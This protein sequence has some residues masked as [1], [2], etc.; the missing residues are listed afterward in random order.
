MRGTSSLLLSTL[1]TTSRHRAKPLLTPAAMTP[2]RVSR[3]PPVDDAD[4]TVRSRYWDNLNESTRPES[5]WPKPKRQ[6]SQT[7]SS[8]HDSTR[9]GPQSSP[10]AP[11]GPADRQHF[12]RTYE[13]AFDFKPR[14]AVNVKEEP[15]EESLTLRATTLTRHFAASKALRP[16]TPAITRKGASVAPKSTEP[17]Q[18]PG[19]NAKNSQERFAVVATLAYVRDSAVTEAVVAHVLRWARQYAASGNG[20]VYDTEF[21]QSIFADLDAISIEPGRRAVVTD[22]LTRP[23]QQ[24]LESLRSSSE[25]LRSCLASINTPQPSSPLSRTRGH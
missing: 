3:N 18:P 11:P 15:Q 20:D 17:T 10:S 24:Q 7:R 22:M 4:N 21:I 5:P 13:D 23:L 6:C 8:G 14:N 12:K 2:K 9:L 25:S 16:S 1:P 19:L